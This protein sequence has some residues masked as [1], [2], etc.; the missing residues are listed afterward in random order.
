MLRE[1]LTNAPESVAWPDDADGGGRHAWVRE[2]G[3]CRAGAGP[4]EAAS[5]PATCRSSAPR[6][7]SPDWVA[8]GLFMEQYLDI[9]D[10]QSAI[11]YAD[12]FARR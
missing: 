2:R 9:L 4:R 1:L 6:R 10:S 7:A 8:A 11:D 3:A 5:T 12:L